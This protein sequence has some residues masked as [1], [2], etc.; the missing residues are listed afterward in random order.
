MLIKKY[1]IDGIPVEIK[2]K[3]DTTSSKEKL[4]MIFDI[5][6]MQIDNEYEDAILNKEKEKLKEYDR[7]TYLITYYKNKLKELIEF[8]SHQGEFKGQK[9]KSRKR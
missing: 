4:L 5:L 6:K 7:Y 3:E 9:T 2:I 1:E 8:E